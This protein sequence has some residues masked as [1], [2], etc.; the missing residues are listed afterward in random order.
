LMFFSSMTT[1][2]RV[3]VPPLPFSPQRRLCPFTATRLGFFPPALRLVLLALGYHKSPFFPFP[4]PLGLRPSFPT[5]DRDGRSFR[6]SHS[7]WNL[8]LPALRLKR[9]FHGRSRHFSLSDHGSSHHQY[10]PLFTD[11]EFGVSGLFSTLQLSSPC[12]SMD[13]N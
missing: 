5:T 3:S 2:S 4:H 12:R 10:I 8:F 7:S 1:F 6:P 9:F 11:V 13:Q